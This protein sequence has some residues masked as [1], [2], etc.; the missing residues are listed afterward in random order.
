MDGPS[1][2]P[3]P[4][5]LPAAA[6]C[7]AAAVGVMNLASALTGELP[8][9]LQA[10]AAFA[11]RELV[12]GAHALALPAGV[13]LIVIARHL[14][15][16]RRRA[17]HVAL[18]LLVG[19]GW[20]NLLKG[21]DVEEAVVSW[22]F[23]A[24]LWWGR[25]AFCV[26]HD[27][28]SLRGAFARVAVLMTVSALTA[29]TAVTVASGGADWLPAGLAL[30]AGFTLAAAAAALF[31]PLSA[32]ARSDATAARRLVEQHGDDTLSFFKLRGDLHHLFTADG[33]AFLSY[34]IEHGVLVVSGDP[35]GHPAA[36]GELIRDLRAFAE[37]RGLR[38][39]VVGAG[40]ASCHLFESAGMRALYLGDEA[41]VETAGFTLEGR[42]MK[43]VRQATHRLGRHGYSCSWHR[44]GDLPPHELDALDSV[45]A[46]WRGGR[47]ERGFSMAM[48]TLRGE[49]V[50][51]ST[52][53]IARDADAEI[54]GFLH[55]VPAYGR[56]AM[57]L[58]AMR[59]DPA[60]PN[61]VIDV[62]VVRAVELCR[63]RGVEELSLNFAAFA[64]LMHDPATRVQRAMG[65][66]VT[67]ANP[68]FQIESLYRFNAKFHP[69]WEPRYLLHE[70]AASF[71]RVALAALAAEGQLPRPGAWRQRPV[72]SA[73]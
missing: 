61:G 44:L 24:L 17:L 19:A 53:V 6:G 3:R 22:A 8:P 63:E 16:R 35:V 56:P 36:L 28:G 73:S 71:P 18:V 64:R 67:L 21:L 54:R 5:W 26:R 31:R 37:A 72:A 60:T 69:R 2:R 45:S 59:R 42:R 65:R 47:P 13:G 7:L 55:L 58:S 12:L 25:D 57:S 46:Q 27:V 14:A 70:G 29:L 41:I 50:A 66:L 15:L 40:E 1:T 48:E 38:I 4:A 39:G 20:L 32:D 30:L 10:L 62:L 23:A 11:P 51:D 9:R 34:T 33:R 43:K 68:L 52:V 49:H